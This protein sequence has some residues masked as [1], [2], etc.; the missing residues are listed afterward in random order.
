MSEGESGG[1]YA[2]THERA[3]LDCTGEDVGCEDEVVVGLVFGVGRVWPEARHDEG[4]GLWLW[5]WLWL[6]WE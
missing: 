6:F 5:L 3:A 2:G 1:A 4:V